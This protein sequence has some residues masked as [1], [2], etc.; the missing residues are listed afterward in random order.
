MK[1]RDME[2]VKCLRLCNLDKDSLMSYYIMQ[3]STVN[4]SKMFSVSLPH[5]LFC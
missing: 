1:P 5:I 4:F 2:W 3:L